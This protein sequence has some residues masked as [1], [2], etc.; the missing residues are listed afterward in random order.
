MSP[1][2]AGNMAKATR[3]RNAELASALRTIARIQDDD[4]LAKWVLGVAAERLGGGSSDLLGRDAWKAQVRALIAD[5]N[6]HNMPDFDDYLESL[7]EEYYDSALADGLT[8]E[9]PREAGWNEWQAAQ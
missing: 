2:E 1:E 8:P 9:T 3:M 4:A 6:G 7:A 5:R